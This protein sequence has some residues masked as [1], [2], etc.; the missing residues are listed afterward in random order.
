MGKVIG[1][2]L[3]TTNSCVAIMDGDAPQVIANS[4]GAR[5]TPSI[6]AFTEHGWWARSPSGRPSRTR[7][8][9]FSR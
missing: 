3:G 5:T 6:V 4:E 9:R 1:I 2:D 7:A 8:R